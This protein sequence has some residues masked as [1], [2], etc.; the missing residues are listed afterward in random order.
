VQKP[1]LVISAMGYSDADKYFFTVKNQGDAAS[2]PFKV[3]V[4]N[5]G[6]YDIP[7][8]AAGASAT[9]TFRT[10]CQVVTNDATADAFGAVEERDETNNTRS[11]TEDV[12]IT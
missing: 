4:S 11:F 2:G 6:T 5:A 9:R 8:L 10:L 3:T 1:D 7:A 12:C